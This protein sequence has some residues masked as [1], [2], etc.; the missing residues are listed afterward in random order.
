MNRTKAVNMRVPH[1]VRGGFTLVEVLVVVIV[2]S[3]LA[4]VVVPEFSNATTSTKDATL[5][6]NLR[7]MRSQIAL[8]KIEHNDSYPS[9]ATFVNEMTLASKADKTTAAIGTSG[10]P[11]GPYVRAIPTNPFN[12]LNTLKATLDGTT[13]WTYNETTG[14]FNANDGAHDTW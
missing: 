6:A 8:F 14:A 10:Y 13:G 2:L 12:D 5:K 9:F 3:V 7:A 1:G 11:Y 4:L